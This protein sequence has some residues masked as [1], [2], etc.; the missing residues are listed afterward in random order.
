M[1]PKETHGYLKIL[2]SIDAQSQK[3]ALQEQ[4]PTQLQAKDQNSLQGGRNQKV[5]DFLEDETGLSW[6]SGAAGYA[7]DMHRFDDSGSEDE[8]RDGGR[9][10]GVSMGRN[11]GQDEVCVSD[12]E[13]C[14][15]EMGPEGHPGSRDWSDLEEEEGAED[16][17]PEGA[18]EDASGGLSD[19]G[20]SKGTGVSGD[21]AKDRGGDEESDEDRSPPPTVL[22]KRSGLGPACDEGPSRLESIAV[23]PLVSRADPPVSHSKASIQ[24][25]KGTLDLS[26]FGS[27]S[28]EDFK[29][30]DSDVDERR[31]SSRLPNDR[32][33]R[34][35]RQ[36]SVSQKADVKPQSEAN[37]Q[38]RGPSRP[39]QVAPLSGVP[40]VAALSEEPSAANRGGNK[41]KASIHETEVPP[42]ETPPRKVEEAQ[43]KSSRKVRQRYCPPA[44][45]SKPIAFSF[46]FVGG[47]IMGSDTRPSFTSS[48]PSDGSTPL[49]LQCF[50]QGFVRSKDKSDQE[51][52]SA[53]DA[54]REALVSDFKSKQR[55]ALR[56]AGRGVGKR[57]AGL[58]R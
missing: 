55:T 38:Q 18:E 42:M 33:S 37:V 2:K 48:M 58:K 16:E 3:Q 10:G 23:A 8:G 34:Q 54:S 43:I 39:L 28:E 41:R 21:A 44:V 12:H 24:G 27:D 29:D 45:P 19:G 14:A 26:R 9:G 13:E 32:E 47:D 51:L 35:T 52:R 22:P 57:P 17:E 4:N 7:G 53:W 20:G 1:R 46:S 11:D 6:E 25:R 31:E 56:H 5:V 15:D 40:L 50:G 30:V 36:K 49:W